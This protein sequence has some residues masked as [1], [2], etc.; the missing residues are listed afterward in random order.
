MSNQAHQKPEHVPDFD[1]FDDVAIRDFLKKIPDGELKPLTINH[2]P[3]SA[4]NTDTVADLVERYR[5]QK[6]DKQSS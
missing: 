6:A 4:R 1:Q 2:V 3:L 5:A